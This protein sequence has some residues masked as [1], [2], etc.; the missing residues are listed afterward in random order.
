MCLEMEA[1]ISFFTGKYHGLF[2]QKLTNLFN[3]LNRKYIVKNI[4]N[5]YNSNSAQKYTIDISTFSNHYRRNEKQTSL[6]K[7]K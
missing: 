5:F 6:R 3:T 7:Y 1:K 4:T 2:C